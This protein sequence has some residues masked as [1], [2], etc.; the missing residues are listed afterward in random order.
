[1]HLSPSLA[2]FQAFAAT[3]I[4]RCI[5][6]VINYWKLEATNY[7]GSEGLVVRLFF[8]TS[9]SSG[10]QDV[11]CF[12][13]LVEDILHGELVAVEPL[14]KLQQILHLLPTM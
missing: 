11:D 7:W 8:L 4:F 10:G 3:D 2:H 14:T 9:T 1:M 12:L 6:K 5:L 13:E